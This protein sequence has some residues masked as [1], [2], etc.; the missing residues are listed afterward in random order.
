MVEALVLWESVANSVWFTK[1]SMILFLNKAD[2]FANKIRDPAQQ[3]QATFPDYGGRPGNYTDG[4][5]YF[6]Q[7]FISLS[8]GQKEVYT[9]VTTAVSGPLNLGSN[10]KAL[11]VTFGRSTLRT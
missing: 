6:K 2:V 4:V 5:Q 3:I 7:R 10:E 1:S 8:R 11:T 9:H